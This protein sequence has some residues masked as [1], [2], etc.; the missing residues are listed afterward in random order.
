[1]V[2]RKIFAWSNAVMTAYQSLVTDHRS[3]SS[4]YGDLLDETISYVG[5]VGSGNFP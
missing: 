1:M 3:R 5:A 4:G 2:I